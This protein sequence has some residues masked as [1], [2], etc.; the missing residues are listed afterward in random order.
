MGLGTGPDG[1]PFAAGV[2]QFEVVAKSNDE[3]VAQIPVET[4]STVN[5]VRLDYG[6][7]IL[8]LDGGVN[9]ASDWVTALRDGNG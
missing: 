2:Y 5:E 4:Y 9:V 3:V 7:T 1:T 6:R 8:V